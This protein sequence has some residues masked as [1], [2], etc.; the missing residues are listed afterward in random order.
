VG[1][2]L[3]VKADLDLLHAVKAF[4]LSADRPSLNNL[5]T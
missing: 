1:I 3:L 4:E 5:N 2:T